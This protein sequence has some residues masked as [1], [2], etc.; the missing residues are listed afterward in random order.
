MELCPSGLYCAKAQNKWL[1]ASFK[2]SKRLKWFPT[3]PSGTEVSEVDPNLSREQSCRPQRHR[4]TVS[5]SSLSD[6]VGRPSRPP[7]RCRAV[8]WGGTG[9]A[10]GC[11]VF[12]DL[13][14]H[15][16]PDNLPSELW[17]FLS[18]YSRAC[19][20]PLYKFP[21]ALPSS[22]CKEKDLEFIPTKV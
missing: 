12:H 10:G 1:W 22:T 6:G 19:G 18:P 2:K 16:D 20:N 7:R 17:A 21:H 5:P 15:S 9:V 4:G 14:L 3:P 8:P 11:S 13:D